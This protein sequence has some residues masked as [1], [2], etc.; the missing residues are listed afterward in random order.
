MKVSSVLVPV[1]GDSCDEEM[2][3]LGCELLESSRSMIHILYVI[4]VERGFPVDADVAPA[5]AKGEQVLKAME[6]VA[7]NYNCQMEAELLQARKAGTAVMIGLGPVGDTAPIDM[8]DFLRNQK[9]LLSSY[10]GAASPHETFDKLIDFYL[11]GQLDVES[12]ITRTYPLE[13][14]NEGFDALA[15]GE[16]GRGIIVF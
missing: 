5:A 13:E 4:E 11:K 14:I 7:R 16:D 9:S 3:R 2:V 8:V 1:S 10:Y 12:L 6:S 15:R